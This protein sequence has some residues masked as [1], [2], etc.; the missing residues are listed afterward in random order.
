MVGKLHNGTPKWKDQ[1]KQMNNTKVKNVFDTEVQHPVQRYRL[2]EAVG[3][4]NEIYKI[5]DE[6]VKRNEITEYAF[7]FG[8]TDICKFLGYYPNEIAAAQLILS[9]KV[10]I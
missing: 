5:L 3:Y 10:P 8:M 6:C 2:E 1:N 4:Y 9:G 7:L